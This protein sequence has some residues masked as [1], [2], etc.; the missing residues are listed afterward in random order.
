MAI[1]ASVP[2]CLPQPGAP[3]PE[4][5]HMVVLATNIAP[6]VTATAALAM[7]P[8]VPPPRPVQFATTA[9]SASEGEED[10]LPFE[11]A[12]TQDSSLD[13]QPRTGSA[14]WFGAA[15]RTRR[16]PKIPGA[17]PPAE[18]APTEAGERAPPLRLVVPVVVFGK[19]VDVCNCAAA[20]VL[21]SRLIPVQTR[22]PL[23]P[24]SATKGSTAAPQRRRLH[25]IDRRKDDRRVQITGVRGVLARTA[26]AASLTFGGLTTGG[27]VVSLESSRSLLD[28]KLAPRSRNW[29]TTAAPASPSTAI[30]QSLPVTITM[31]CDSVHRVLDSVRPGQPSKLQ[32]SLKSDFHSREIGVSFLPWKVEAACDFSLTSN[33]YSSLSSYQ[34]STLPCLCR[35]VQVALLSSPSCTGSGPLAH[36]LSSLCSRTTGAA[37]RPREAAAGLS[38]QPLCQAAGVQWLDL[39]TQAAT[40][41][42]W[43][44]RLYR[45]AQRLQSTCRYR[46]P[47]PL[48]PPLL[49]LSY[50]TPHVPTNPLRPTEHGGGALYDLHTASG[51]RCVVG[52][53]RRST[54][55]GARYWPAARWRR[56]TQQPR[57]AVRRGSLSGGVTRSWTPS[58]GFS[59]GGAKYAPKLPEQQR[60]RRQKASSTYYNPTM[61]TNC[62]N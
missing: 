52:W 38:P 10:A 11:L 37:Y 30:L 18:E 39:T 36:A 23:A 57:Q 12:A 41:T 25:Q 44:G 46:Y 17:L 14:S 28:P 35:L 43:R 29:M 5:S 7:A 40:L 49:F 60:L 13:P 9:N 62:A 3:T 56:L 27:A 61:L 31:P 53:Q 45:F 42:R 58:R 33:P 48:A 51:P 32:L 55:A 8:L 47:N 16:S 50:A 15:G 54:M 34:H 21:G 26:K 22:L 4:V 6:R 2:G 59:P 1:L 19:G 20:E 24:D